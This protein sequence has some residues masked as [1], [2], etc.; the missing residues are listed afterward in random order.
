MLYEVRIAEGDRRDN[1]AARHLGDAEL[2]WR[3][4]DGN[5][6]VDPRE[7]TGPPGRR[8]RITLAEGVQGPS[9]G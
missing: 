9:D 7:L 5:G 6:A 8:L 4:A 1:L 3:L 2:W